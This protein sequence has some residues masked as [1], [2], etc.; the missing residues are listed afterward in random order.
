MPMMPTDWDGAIPMRERK[1]IRL[2]WIFVAAF[3]VM[4]GVSTA[5]ADVGLLVPSYFYPGTGGPG[6]VGDGWA[7]MTAA[8][9]QVPI[10]AVLNP[11]S[12]PGPSED[13]NYAAAMTNLENA[14]GRVVAYVFT[15]DGNAP[16]GAVE[17]QISTYIAQYGNLINGFFLDGMFI[18]PSTLS[19][20]QS[21]DSY[22]KGLSQGYTVI[23]NPGQ[24]FLNG[25]T[26]QQYLST[27]DVFNIFE[28]PNKA[29]APGAAGFDAYPYGLNWF[30]S[31]PS[32]RFDNT[33]FDV[34]TASAMVADLGKAV[35]LNAGHV[36]ITDQTL[37]NPY[38]QLPSYWDQEV[39]AVAS[40]PEP[41]SLTIVLTTGGLL[42]M[43]RLARR[44]FA[45]AS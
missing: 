41:S 26:P 15:N 21:L 42:G 22:I 37:P 31:Y 20:Y 40:I 43:A 33:I 7:A 23:G 13:P 5:R 32:N 29:P 8:A 11:S 14:G 2:P 44:R 30:L 9:G 10:T 1:R 18:T 36:Y 24:P 4:A 28:G 3:A 35:S 39:A 38:G 16:L 25:V 6:G 45:R 17:G 12:G 34:P 19:Y 27:A